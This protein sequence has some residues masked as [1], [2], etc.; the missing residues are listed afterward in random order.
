M[1]VIDFEMRFLGSLFGMKI[2]MMDVA[3]EGN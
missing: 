1:T 3:T 2:Q